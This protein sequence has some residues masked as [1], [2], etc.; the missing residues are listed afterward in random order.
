M[1]VDFPLEVMLVYCEKKAKY[2]ECLKPY[3]G[4]D[5]FNQPA[6]EICTV[7]QAS[8]YTLLPLYK[9]EV[10]VK[11]EKGDDDIQRSYN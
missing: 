4:E 11:I 5:P 6:P 7:G 10:I 3:G 8:P 9:D 2:H 1:G